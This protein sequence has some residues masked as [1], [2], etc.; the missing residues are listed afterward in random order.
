MLG[1]F[2]EVLVMDWGVAR[3]TG[4]S[5]AL[6]AGTRGFMAPEQEQGAIVDASTDVFALGAMLRAILPSNLPRPLA[7][8][9]AK[10]SAAEK[11]NRYTTVPALATDIANWLE[12]QPVIAYRENVVE[13]VGRWVTRNR[14]L[15]TIVLAYLV[16]RVIV[17][18][19]V[20]R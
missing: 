9:C 7:A 10:A 18:L 15:V 5:E 20:H 14:A 19:W 3:Q 8:I 1:D 11:V 17:I 2:G 13:R 16:M 12:N 6:I 4:A